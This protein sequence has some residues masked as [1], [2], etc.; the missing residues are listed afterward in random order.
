MPYVDSKNYLQKIENLAQLF[1][2]IAL[3]NSACK[4]D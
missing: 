2:L 1:L 3:R 4:K